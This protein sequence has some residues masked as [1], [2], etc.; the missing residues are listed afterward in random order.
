[1]YIFQRQKFEFKEGPSNWEK[2]R[3]KSLGRLLVVCLG[4]KVE[5][6]HRDGERISVTEGQAGLR[7]GKEMCP[8]L[9]KKF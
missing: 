9:H 6:G 3:L 4:A 2:G 5:D 1:M 7:R 8:F